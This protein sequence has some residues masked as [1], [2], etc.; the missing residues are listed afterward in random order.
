MGRRVYQ[1]AR[2]AALRTEISFADDDASKSIGSFA[3]QWPLETVELSFG[4][5]AYK[6]MM[7]K[8]VKWST[9]FNSRVKKKMR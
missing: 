8:S 2:P 9:L 1:R 7:R 6:C 4:L 5:S 3:G